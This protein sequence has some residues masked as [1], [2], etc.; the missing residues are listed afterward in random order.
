M[1]ALELQSILDCAEMAATASLY[2]EESRWG[3]YHYR[4]DFPERNQADWFCHAQLVKNGSGEMSC[5]KRPVAPY[6]IPLS[7][8]EMG[9]YD[10]L[11]IADKPTIAA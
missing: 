8:S 2:R 1:R 4:V 6:V 10:K 9:A 3:L 11:R 7:E 5:H